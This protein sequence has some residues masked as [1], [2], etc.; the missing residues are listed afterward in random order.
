MWRYIVIGV[1]LAGNVVAAP[2]S[3]FKAL[4][5]CVTGA[6]AAEGNVAQRVQSPANA[7]WEDAYVGAIM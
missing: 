1:V 7:T 4:Q 2:G 6:L 3:N 5:K